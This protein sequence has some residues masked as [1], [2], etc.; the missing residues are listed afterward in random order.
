MLKE[1]SFYPSNRVDYGASSPTTERL[2]S[3]KLKNE[4]D[5]LKR[6]QHDLEGRISAA[7]SGM[8]EEMDADL[9]KIYKERKTQLLEDLKNKISNSEMLLKIDQITKRGELTAEEKTELTKEF[10]GE[11]ASRWSSETRK[12]LIGLLEK[13]VD[14]SRKLSA[15]EE[16][17]Y[18]DLFNFYKLR[19]FTQ[20]NS[21]RAKIDVEI[22]KL[23]K[24]LDGSGLDTSVKAVE[25][26]LGRRIIDGNYFSEPAKESTIS[27]DNSESTPPT[28]PPSEQGQP[29]TPPVEE[30]N[31]GIV[32]NEDVISSHRPTQQEPISTQDQ[33]GTT[34]AETAVEKPEEESQAV[35][36]EEAQ[37]T[38]EAVKGWI[39]KIGEIATELS[40]KHKSLDDR[41]FLHFNKEGAKTFLK[42]SRDDIEKILNDGPSSNE[43]KTK[44]N[45]QQIDEIG[46]A[47]QKADAIATLFSDLIDK[48]MEIS[49]KSF[50]F[51]DETAPIVKDE[52]SEESSPLGIIRFLPRRLRKFFSGETAESKPDVIVEQAQKLTN[53]ANRLEKSNKNQEARE[54]YQ[55]AVAIYRELIDSDPNNAE[56]YFNLGNTLRNWGQVDFAQGSHYEEAEKAYLQAIENDKGN[57]KYQRELEALRRHMKRNGIE[58]SDEKAGAQG[59]E[60]VLNEG[61]G[62][63]VGETDHEDEGGLPNAVEIA[64]EVVDTQSPASKVN[65]PN[66]DEIS[67]PEPNAEAIKAEIDSL[68]EGIN[69]G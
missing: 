37:K 22:S 6:Q 7:L 34:P 42:D 8:D 10:N 11:N 15:G 18:R 59:D 29:L 21:E 30:K 66:V 35:V 57:K 2:D 45:Q 31:V 36:D 32:P 20:D 49:E 62:E 55:K 67:T 13:G 48:T 16:S 14:K 28:P 5:D 50:D 43:W 24:S 68:L 39:E 60:A 12:A 38:S 33:V 26:K 27:V 65:T 56:H 1:K 61:I 58:T 41:G 53:E 19:Y 44:L 46:A 17:D 9:I 63:D 3:E 23:K 40:E 25:D 51:D 52:D 69:F 64:A 4:I 47:K 54:T